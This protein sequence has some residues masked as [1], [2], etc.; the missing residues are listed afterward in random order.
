MYKRQIS[1]IYKETEKYGNGYRVAYL[2]G[3][4]SLVEQRKAE[5]EQKRKG[6]SPEIAK[7]PD[8]YRKEYLDMLGWPLNEEPK[9]FLSITENKIFENENCIFYRMQLELFKGYKFYG[10]LLEHILIIH[11]L[12][13]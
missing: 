4:K 5:C 13:L 3:V 2:K 7:N 8:K 1:P 9:K 11:L 12:L 6:L 10:I